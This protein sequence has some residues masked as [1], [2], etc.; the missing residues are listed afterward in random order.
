M[1]V[2]AAPPLSVS[3]AVSVPFLKWAGGKRQLVPAL[4]PFLQGVRGKRYVE[5]FV[6]GGAV[7]FYLRGAGLLEGACVLADANEELIN[8]YRVV[9]G[10]VDKLIGELRIHQQKHDS[11]YFYAMRARQYT[12]DCAGAART[13]YLNRT[14]FNGLYR[15]NRRGLFNVPLG[16]YRNPRICDEG[17][18]HRASQALQGVELRQ[19]DFEQ[20][21][22]ECG[23][24]DFLYLDP[25]YVPIS[26]TSNFT[27]YYKEG[28]GLP[29]QQRLAASCRAA[30]GRGAE[31]VLSNSASVV[32][33]GL[34]EGFPI[35]TVEATRR[36]NCSAEKRG[37]V[38]EMIVLGL[39]R[40]G[41]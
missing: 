26:S 40:N 1:S 5:P 2:V 33:E 28:F 20:V 34:F 8:V 22:N 16:R 24:S 38:P 17:R 18:L 30:H 41:R 21:I 9:Q 13:I 29:E 35:E 19:A 37:A 27:S 23:P 4:A 3:D 31:F 7:F 12:P 39:H 10:H 14:G 11:E 32:V 15:V 6:G 36:I 25:P